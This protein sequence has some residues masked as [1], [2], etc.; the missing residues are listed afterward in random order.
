MTGHLQRYDYVRPADIRD[1]VRLGAEGWQIRSSDD[2][3]EWM[4]TVPGSDLGEPL[5]FVVDIDGVLRVA[6]R[7][8]EYVACAGGR[9]VLSAGE[10]VQDHS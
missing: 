8:S 10:Q 3:T 2:L 1:D 4:A 6:P 7:R 9:P 5:T